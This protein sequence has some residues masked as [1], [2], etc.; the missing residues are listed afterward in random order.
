MTKKVCNSALELEFA[1]SFAEGFECRFPSQR[2]IYRDNTF[3]KMSKST[4]Q[5][6][7]VIMRYLMYCLI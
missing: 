3:R 4:Y 5:S 2:L 7:L 6:N 1:G